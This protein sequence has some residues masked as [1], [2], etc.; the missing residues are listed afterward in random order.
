MNNS[1]LGRVQTSNFS[2]PNLACQRKICRCELKHVT[3]FHRQISMAKMSET[4]KIC[5]CKPRSLPNISDKVSLYRSGK[6]SKVFTGLLAFIKDV[7]CGKYL[8]PFARPAK[9]TKIH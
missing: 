8:L 1:S 9:K 4:S 5:S 6:C 3:K 7:G 2:L